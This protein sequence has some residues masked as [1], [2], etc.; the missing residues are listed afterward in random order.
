M[1][2]T[3]LDSLTQGEAL[4]QARNDNDDL[5]AVQYGAHTNGQGHLWY[6]VN[7]VIEK[8]GIGEDGIV[9][10]CFDTCAGGKG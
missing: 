2:H 6:S 3:V 1:I 4:P 9:R 8:T 7:V 5:P 10:Q